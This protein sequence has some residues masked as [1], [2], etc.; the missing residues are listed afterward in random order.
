[1]YYTMRERLRIE[2]VKHDIRGDRYEI[3][4]SGNYPPCEYE[5]H[6]KRRKNNSSEKAYTIK[7]NAKADNSWLIIARIQKKYAEIKIR[8]DVKKWRVKLWRRPM[9]KKNRKWKPSC[10]PLAMSLAE[11]TGSPGLKQVAK[12]TSSALTSAANSGPCKN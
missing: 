5:S 10:E 11:T 2:R 7:E 6:K 8:K 12:S 9:M 3:C 4:S 1:M